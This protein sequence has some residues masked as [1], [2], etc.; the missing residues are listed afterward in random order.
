MAGTAFSVLS[1]VRAAARFSPDILPHSAMLS[2]LA[3]LAATP[4]SH[5]RRSPAVRC[6]GVSAELSAILVEAE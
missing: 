4:L 3:R 6:G 5:A 2:C 1:L